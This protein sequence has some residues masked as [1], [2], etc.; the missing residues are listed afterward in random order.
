MLLLQLFQSWFGIGFRTRISNNCRSKDFGQVGNRHFAIGSFSHSEQTENEIYFHYLYDV[1]SFSF[2]TAEGEEWRRIEYLG[3]AV[4]NRE[5]GNKRR[6]ARPSHRLSR[7]RE[8][9]CPTSCTWWEVPSTIGR[10]TSRCQPQREYPLVIDEVVLY[11]ARDVPKTKHPQIRHAVDCLS[12]TREQFRIF[13]PFQ[14][15]YDCSL[16][17]LHTGHS[18]Q[19]IYF[20]LP[21]K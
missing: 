9:S 16:I 21:E 13:K 6:S 10:M 3:W 4:A 8:Q 2:V 19:R 20:S 17:S 12:N 18:F 5:S 1:R 11:L 14:P 7:R 15:Q